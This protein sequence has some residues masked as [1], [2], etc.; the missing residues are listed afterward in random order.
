M[1][2]MKSPLR[3]SR[4]NVNHSR[5]HSNTQEEHGGSDETQGPHHNEIKD[6]HN[7]CR[8]GALLS[9]SGRL[10]AQWV[11]V[12]LSRHDCLQAVRDNSTGAYLLAART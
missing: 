5:N 8:R 3:A 9:S 7:S 10:Y 12:H 11:S 4:N 1:L 2:K 6:H